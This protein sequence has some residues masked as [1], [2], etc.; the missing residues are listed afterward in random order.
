ME[1]RSKL[2]IATSYSKKMEKKIT[3]R[4]IITFYSRMEK[5]KIFQKKPFLT[6]P[7]LVWALASSVFTIQTTFTDQNLTLWIL[8]KSN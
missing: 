4:K 3:K 5:H 2:L 7:L 1:K 8:V 6:L